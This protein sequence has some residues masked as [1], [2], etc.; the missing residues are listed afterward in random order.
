MARNT[1]GHVAADDLGTF[2]RSAVPQPILVIEH[3]RRHISAWKESIVIKTYIRF[4]WCSALLM[5][6]SP[7]LATVVLAQDKPDIA[8]CAAEQDSVKRL[9]CFD[10][11]AK[12]LE[13]A[14]AKLTTQVFSKWRVN[15]RIS[16]L[17][18]SKTVVL[19]IR[20][21]SA[22]SGWPGKVYTPILILRCQQRKTEAYVTTGMSPNVELGLHDQ[23]TVT[24]R[25][26]KE[27][28]FMTVTGKATDG[29]ALFFRDGMTLIL[30]MMKYETMLFQF[31]P[32][33]SSAVLTTFDLRGIV[34]AVQPLRAQCG[35]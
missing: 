19:S 20:A 8:K 23:A 17:D 26:D 14:D 16:P 29:Q 30:Q 31:V 32:Y 3:I 7:F 34:D 35:W 10:A 6:G 27:K 2:G 22:I 18:D 28:A 4:V 5:I 33:N 13:V 21:E 1:D 25:F 9:E 24:L 12:R 11:L 15:T